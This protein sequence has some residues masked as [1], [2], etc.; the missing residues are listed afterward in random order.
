MK[1]GNG[2]RQWEGNRRRQWERAVG[3]AMKEGNRG[4]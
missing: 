4:R 3:E 2:G 1:E